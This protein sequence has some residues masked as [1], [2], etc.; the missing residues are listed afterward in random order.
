MVASGP[1]IQGQGYAAEGPTGTTGVHNISFT[2]TPNNGLVAIE[3]NL[4]ADGDLDND[5]NL[6]GNPYPS[7]INIDLFFWK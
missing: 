6:I 2:G 5:F 3:L 7:A 4:W 1:M